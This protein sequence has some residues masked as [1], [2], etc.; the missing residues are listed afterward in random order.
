[1]EQTVL[2]PEQLSSAVAGRLRR[3][4]RSVDE[5]SGMRIRPLKSSHDAFER[6]RFV[7][8]ILRRE[9]MVREKWRR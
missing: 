3:D 5:E 2:S 6:D 7:R 8:V 1:M 4:C 9:G